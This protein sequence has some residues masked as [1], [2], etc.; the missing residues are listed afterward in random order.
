[1]KRADKNLKNLFS[2]CK[3]ILD[4]DPADL[5]FTEGS[6]SVEQAQVAD[7]NGEFMSFLLKTFL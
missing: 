4:L 6:V 1:M 2:H 3:K 5:V 7:K